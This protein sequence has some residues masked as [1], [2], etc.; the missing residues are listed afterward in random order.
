[1][2]ESILEL[3]EIEFR[4]ETEALKKEIDRSKGRESCERINGDVWGEA[5][6]TAIANIKDRQLPYALEV[7]KKSDCE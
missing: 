7:S 2:A 3:C 6:K 5:Y 1:M 4:R